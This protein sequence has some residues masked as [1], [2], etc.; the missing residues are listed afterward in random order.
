MRLVLP[1]AKNKSSRPQEPELASQ[2]AAYSTQV[3][4]SAVGNDKL[5]GQKPKK[6]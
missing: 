2:N 3:T 4:R 5:K 6:S 1:I